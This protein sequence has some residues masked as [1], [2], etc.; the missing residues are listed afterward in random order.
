MSEPAPGPDRVVV[1]GGLFETGLAVAA[2]LGA[3]LFE[4]PLGDYLA[5][6]AA[7]AALGA[8]AALPLLPFFWL[9]LHVPLPRLHRIRELSRDLIRPL[10]EACS[11]VELALISLLAGVAEELLF[12]GTL[13]L[14]LSAGLDDRWTGLVLASVAFGLAHAITPTYAILATAM[15]GYL[16]AI[17]LCTDNLLA[18][19]VAHAVYDFVALVYLTRSRGLAQPARQDSP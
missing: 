2:L 7:D 11:L 14:A 8:A 3:W 16:G 9:C 5:W 19:I 13:Q 6:D 12:R 18:A 4:V 17:F 10:F 15:G 1:L